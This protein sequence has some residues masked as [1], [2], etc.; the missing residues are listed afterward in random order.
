MIMEKKAYL[1][2]QSEVVKMVGNGIIM[3]TSIPTASDPAPK[4]PGGPIE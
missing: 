3:I 2:P 1:Q 4:F